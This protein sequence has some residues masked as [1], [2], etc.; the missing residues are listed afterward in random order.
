MNLEAADT[1]NRFRFRFQNSAVKAAAMKG[2]NDLKNTDAGWMTESIL[3]RRSS[4]P[5]P[6]Y[7]MKF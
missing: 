1:A 3:P 6:R 7:T 4:D 5:W 2:D